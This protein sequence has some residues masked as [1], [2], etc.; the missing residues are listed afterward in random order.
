MRELASESVA[1]LAM[2]KGVPYPAGVRFRQILVTGPPGSGKT[3]LVSKLGGW[4]EEGYLDLAEGWWR[5]SSL[6]LRPREVHFGIPFAGHAESLAV[7]DPEWEASRAEVELA[8]VRIPALKRRFY[9]IE[10]RRKFV[11]D[12]QLLPSD[13]L[14]DVRRERAKTGLHPVDRSLTPRL[15]ADQVAVYETLAEHLHR[16]GFEVYLRRDFVG[17]PRRIIT[18]ARRASLE[19]AR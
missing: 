6:S 15:V 5:S 9:Q 11:F 1:E 3:T 14:F 13:K 2:L 17:P 8:R 19:A 16:A 4:P 10:W 7:F 18:S 12:F